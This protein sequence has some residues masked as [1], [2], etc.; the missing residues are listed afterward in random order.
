[1]THKPLPLSLLSLYPYLI[2]LFLYY[3]LVSLSGYGADD[4]VFRMIDSGQDLFLNH[5]Y[6]P[7]R[8]Q[9]YLIPEITI[10][11]TSLIGG[12]YLSNFISVLLGV[13]VL[14]LFYYFISKI[15]DRE[16]SLV[17]T[18]I[19]GFNP[20]FVIAAS[21]SIDYIYGLFFFLTGTFSLHKKH[22]TV[23]AIIFALALSSRMANALLVGFVF[24]YFLAM[25]YKYDKKTT[26]KIFIT[27]F[28][29]LLLT[30][31]L[32]IPAYIAS[33]HTF[34]FLDY[35]IQGYDWTGY[36]TRFVYKNIAFISLPSTLFLYGFITYNLIRK[37][38]KFK[39]SIALYFIIAAVI[40][41]QLKF[42][43]IPIQI[44]FL[45]PAFMLMVSLYPYLLKTKVPLYIMLGLTLFYN[46][47]SIDF[48]RFT[49]G[50][51]E[52]DKEGETLVATGAELG[53]FIE[54]G[55]ISQ[56]IDERELSRATY[57]EKFNLPVQK[58]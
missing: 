42:L 56:N 23:A 49:Y 19:V 55:I 39:Q 38:I 35:Y 2:V 53:L 30:L 40:V 37:R 47:V 7:S 11:V 34:K 27:G 57:F 12:H 6:H 24:S 31:V 5:T 3:V 21:S 50:V 4:D 32:Y 26:L 22:Y 13:G 8:F 17:L 54:R 43:K 16:I 28:I 29:A 14:Y 18:L 48:L 41:E 25:N 46:L 33:D 45:L 51:D 44:S 58:K 20:Y 36:I 10:G 9:G 15:F 1:M 52:K